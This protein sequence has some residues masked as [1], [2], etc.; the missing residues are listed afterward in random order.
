MSTCPILNNGY[1]KGWGEWVGYFDE[2]LNGED[3]IPLKISVVGGLRHIS[4][5]PGAVIVNEEV[6]FFQPSI[7]IY[8]FYS[9]CISEGK[10]D[11]QRGGLLCFL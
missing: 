7:I 9:V 11:G 6:I 3:N 4:V 1:M 2:G 10:K 5:P 8:R